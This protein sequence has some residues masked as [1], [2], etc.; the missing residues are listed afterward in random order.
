MW[1]NT[2]GQ[3]PWR[4]VGELCRSLC[5]AHR[6]AGVR[7]VCE[8]WDFS[9]RSLFVSQSV[10]VAL[11]ATS[12]HSNDSHAGMSAVRAVDLRVG[13]LERRLEAELVSR[14]TS[15]ELLVE[16]LQSHFA[17]SRYESTSSLGALC[18]LKPMLRPLLNRAAQF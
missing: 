3:P 9:W 7:D 2:R 15:V 11:A 4:L 16:A 13:V 1:V 17:E 10:R 5:V 18:C 8:V 14:M 6:G 12:H